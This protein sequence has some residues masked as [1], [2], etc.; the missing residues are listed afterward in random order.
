MEPVAFTH[1]ER[2]ARQ[3]QI[4]RMPPMVYAHVEAIHF[5]RQFRIEPENIARD[6]IVV[7]ALHEIDGASHGAEMHALRSGAISTPSRSNKTAS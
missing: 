3:P 7:D 6:S 1:G 2:V 5:P 4:E